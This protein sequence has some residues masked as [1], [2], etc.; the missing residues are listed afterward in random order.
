VERDPQHLV[1][2]STE[3]RRE[4][5]FRR[6]AHEADVLIALAGF[7]PGEIYGGLLWYARHGPHRR[8]KD[9]YAACAFREIFG[10]WPRPRDKGAPVRPPVVL[11]EWV[12]ARQR[13]R[14]PKARETAA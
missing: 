4:R 9:E 5:R 13:R 3:Y 2:G 11:E 12:I 1:R 6:L 7:A 8:W 10:T 14:R